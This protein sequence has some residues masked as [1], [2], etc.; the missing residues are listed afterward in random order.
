MGMA[1]I[2]IDLGAAFNERRQDQSSADSAA[3][4]AGVEILIGSGE[5][6]AV[7]AAK[8]FVNQ[9]LGRTLSAAQWSQCTDPDF[10]GLTGNETA[11]G[12]N[13]VQPCIS[14]GQSSG[15]QAFSLIRVRVPIQETATTFGRVLGV[16]ALKTSAAAEVEL[17]PVLQSGSF[18]ASVFNGT[19]AGATVCI[20]TGTGSA[21][22]TSCGSP[23]TGN[24]GNFNPY[25]YTEIHPSNPNSMCNAG[26][27]VDALGFIMSNGLDHSLGIAPGAGLGTRV[28]GASCPQSPGPIN[29]D[30]VR[31]GSGYSNNDVTQGLISGGTWD[32]TPY[33]GRLTKPT[34]WSGAYGSATI[35]NRAVDNR[36]LWTFIDSGQ[37][38]LV[39]IAVNSGTPA[40]VPPF[41]ACSD[42]ADGPSFITALA[43]EPDFEDAE[44]ALIQCL[45]AFAGLANPPADGLFDEALYD[46]PRLT[47]VPEYHQLGPIGNN[48]CCYDV[49]DFRPVYLNSVWS[50]HGPQWTCDDG[51][52][53]TVSGDYCRHDPGRSGNITINAAGQQRVDSANAFVLNCNMLAG[54]DAPVDRC[55][56]I[57]TTSG[58]TVTNFVNLFLTK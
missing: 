13:S 12:L 18:P 24:F 26:S 38:T 40:P 9:N 2:A 36:P 53:S 56:K 16:F 21:N 10:V 51:A 19:P 50:A 35:F 52:M 15:G 11:N 28:N 48:S 14:F 57:E 42:A 25:F 30:R 34:P 54:L 55:K 37:A 8:N 3:L 4:A 6:Q 20:K 46:S 43:D 7:A 45:T 17:V 39:D 33:L 31:S 49:K 5:Q 23:S 29:P 1:A 47:I 27:S 41:T 58:N 22:H 32:S 44:A